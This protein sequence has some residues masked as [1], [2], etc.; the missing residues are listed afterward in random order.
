[1]NTKFRQ[2]YKRFTQGKEYRF[3]PC[4]I[5]MIRNHELRYLF[6][7]RLHENNKDS[8]MGGAISIIMSHYRRKYGLE[9]AFKM[10]H[11]G[12][13]LRLIHPW[14]ITVN[15]NAVLGD[16]VTLFKGCT[17]GVIDNG[18]KKGNPVL[19][20]NVTLYANSTVCGN[21]R[22]GSNVE[23]AAGAFVNFDV[24]DNAIVIGNPGVFHERKTNN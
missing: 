15:D 13:G 18:P 19:G 20:N 11:I 22:I 14:D 16:N 21:I 23:I 1:M 5:R 8:L 9:I 3:L 2:D 6:W 7:G 24:P 17:I 4:I 10:R 12:A